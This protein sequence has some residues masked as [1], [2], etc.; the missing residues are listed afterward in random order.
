[1]GKFYQNRINSYFVFSP[2]YQGKKYGAK[3]TL[4]RSFVCAAVLCALLFAGCRS[5]NRS[6]QNFEQKRE[7]I[8]DLGRTVKIPVRVERAVSLAPNLTEIVF[9]VGAGEKLVGV[10]SY[11]DYPP[12]A[13]NIAKIGDTLKPNIE[14]I[15]ALKPEIVFVSTASQIETFTGTLEG[16][17]IAYFVTNPD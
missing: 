6:P 11:C 5:E 9:A 10:T 8:D 17:N 15:V 16:Q 7:A 2:Y 3:I 4:T 14:T 13:E 1:L 12:E